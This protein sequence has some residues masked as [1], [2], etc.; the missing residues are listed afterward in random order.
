MSGTKFPPNIKQIRRARIK[1]GAGPSPTQPA[2]PPGT[3]GQSRFDFRS[4]KVI[5]QVG[6]Q[7]PCGDC[8]AF[9]TIGN[10]EALT[11]LFNGGELIMFSEQYLLNCTPP[12]PSAPSIQ[13][14][15]SGGFWGDALDLM[16]NGVPYVNA[17]D[18]DDPWRYT[19]VKGP[20]IGNP[21]RLFRV[22]DWEFVDDDPNVLIPTVP[23]IKQALCTFGPI[24]SGVKGGTF[25]FSTY[26]GGVLIENDQSQ[27][28]HAILIIGW[29][30]DAGGPG[31]G[32]WLIKNSWGKTWGFN[33]FG[34]VGY[35]TNSIGF[36]A[37]YA[38]PVLI[39]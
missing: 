28:D 35:Q 23:Q 15:C 25:L 9:A 37:T 26:T 36:Q 10:Y 33:G 18:P 32:A 5:S 29:D 16:K 8:W 39:Q 14:D 13:N 2:A 34:Y 21:P 22:S 38:T 24:I 7:D 12:D 17:N 11:A 19:G 20:C 31:V 3:A 6:D 27:P 4:M 1:V 30:D